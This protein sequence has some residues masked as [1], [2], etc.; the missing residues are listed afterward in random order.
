MQNLEGAGDQKSEF[1]KHRIK[2]YIHNV[3]PKQLNKKTFNMDAISENFCR[4]CIAADDEFPEALELLRPWLKPSKYPDN[5]IQELLRVN[6]C[7]KFPEAALIYLNCIVG[8]NPFWIRSHLQ[9]CLNVIQ[10]TN[11]KLTFDENFQNLS[12]LVRKL[13]N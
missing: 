4:L 1:W 5:L 3:W 8:E 13:D 2:P 9:E 10:T 12:I 11:P 6:I 7:L